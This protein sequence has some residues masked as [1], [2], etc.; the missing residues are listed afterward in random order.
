ML[1]CASVDQRLTGTDSSMKR[2][3][4]SESSPL[5]RTAAVCLGAS[6]LKPPRRRFRKLPIGLSGRF[7][8]ERGVNLP[9]I[10]SPIAPGR[11]DLR[12]DWLLQ[13]YRDESMGAISD[14]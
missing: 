4:R 11:N 2:R 10:L 5:W 12:P 14:R 1:R 6:D 9:L 3:R 7:T 8:R 13:V